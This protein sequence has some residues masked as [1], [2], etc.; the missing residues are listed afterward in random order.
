MTQAK[1]SIRARQIEKIQ[2][3]IGGIR[4][5]FMT[6]AAQTSN[7]FE[8]MAT[9][10]A[11]LAKVLVVVDMLASGGTVPLEEGGEAVDY[12]AVKLKSPT[13]EHKNQDQQPPEEDS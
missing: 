9:V 5:D 3:F 6:L 8:R 13:E 11:Q 12:S 10:E 2:N 1:K 7:T 4:S